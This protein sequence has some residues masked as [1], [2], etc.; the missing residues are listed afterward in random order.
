MPM[1]G[2]SNKFPKHKA[3]S[4][5]MRATPE[6]RESLDNQ[7]RI[8]EREESNRKVFEAAQ[9][10]FGDLGQQRVLQNSE[11]FYYLP[12]SA[13]PRRPDVQ[14]DTNWINPFVGPGLGV[15]DTKALD[16]AKGILGFSSGLA[17]ADAFDQMQQRARASLGMK[18]TPTRQ[19]RMVAQHEQGQDAFSRAMRAFR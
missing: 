9:A 15:A 4:G 10:Q 14:G 13:N 12:Q 17:Q 2:W 3:S 18:G 5:Y 11:G 7:A 16:D 6:E 8:A 1:P 19:D